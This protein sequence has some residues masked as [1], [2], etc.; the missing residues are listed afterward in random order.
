LCET[1][2]KN[3]GVA[4]EGAAWK[5]SGEFIVLDRSGY[6]EDKGPQTC[7]GAVSGQYST[8]VD[9]DQSRF[10][11]AAMKTASNQPIQALHTGETTPQ[12]RRAGV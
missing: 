12:E 2:H 7:R 5:R 11:V 9:D 6:S 1:L 4:I 8:N 10:Q 3:K